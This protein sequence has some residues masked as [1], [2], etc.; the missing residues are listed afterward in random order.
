MRPA[1]FGRGNLPIG[2]IEIQVPWRR[3]GSRCIGWSFQA[4]YAKK[5]GN[6]TTGRI[7]TNLNAKTRLMVLVGRA[8]LSQ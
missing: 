2:R 5:R 8:M 7:L 6:K 3:G 1:R 4:A